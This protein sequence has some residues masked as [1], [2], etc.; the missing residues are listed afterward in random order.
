MSLCWTLTLACDLNTASLI[1]FDIIAAPRSVTVYMCMDYTTPLAPPSPSHGPNIMRLTGSVGLF[2][3]LG[4]FFFCLV[5]RGRPNLVRR[6]PSVCHVSLIVY[7]S[8]IAR[9]RRRRSS[10]Q[11][12]SHTIHRTIKSTSFIGVGCSQ[13]AI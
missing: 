9:R 1:F 12:V 2:N 3:R 13:H 6:C 5:T 4:V 10:G 11:S 7:L 8:A